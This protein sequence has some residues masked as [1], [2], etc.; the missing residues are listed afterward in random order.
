MSKAIVTRALIRAIAQT[1]PSGF[2]SEVRGNVNNYLRQ[3]HSEQYK[4]LRRKVKPSMIRTALLTDRTFQVSGELYKH[5][6]QFLIKRRNN[7]S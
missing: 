7:N 5:K 2:L 1:T 4:S 3:N 6:P